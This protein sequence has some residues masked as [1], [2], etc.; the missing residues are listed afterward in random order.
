MRNATTDALAAQLQAAYKKS[1]LTPHE[2]VMHLENSR[3]VDVEVTQMGYSF[4][5]VCNDL[6]AQFY[7]YEEDDQWFCKA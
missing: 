5:V 4:H 3:G 7:F 1:A 6:F 2:F